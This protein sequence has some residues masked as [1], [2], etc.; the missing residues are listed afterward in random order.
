MRLGERR[1]SALWLL[2]LQEERAVAYNGVCSEKPPTFA[3]VNWDGDQ[4]THSWFGR[5]GTCSIRAEL[6][7]KAGLWVWQSFERK[8]EFTALQTVAMHVIK[9]AKHLVIP[10]KTVNWSDLVMQ[11]K[12]LWFPV[13]V[14][15][16]EAGESQPHAMEHAACPGAFP[17]QFP[18]WKQWRICFLV[19]L[20]L[21]STPL[22]SF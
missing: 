21:K 12:S 8:S 13:P 18:N 5:V 9:N 4:H 10:G 6:H 15:A 11:K 20:A 2:M 14:P 3:L 17:Q 22:R 7:L 16:S 1:I 19:R